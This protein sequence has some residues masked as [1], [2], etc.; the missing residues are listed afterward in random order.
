MP[1]FFSE[2]VYVRDYVLSDGSLLDPPFYSV[3]MDVRRDDEYKE[4]GAD[5]RYTYA[6]ATAEPSRGHTDILGEMEQGEDGAVYA[7][8]MAMIRGHRQPVRVRFRPLTVETF[9]DLSESMVGW[10]ELSQE[11]QTTEDL[12]YFF[13][14]MLDEA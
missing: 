14:L 1:L 7:Y 10:E 9:R 2:T 8:D 4:A 5:A 3:V 11:L 12:Q 13:R 6:R